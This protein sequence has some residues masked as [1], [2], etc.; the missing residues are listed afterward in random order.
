MR[1]EM[2]RWPVPSTLSAD[3]IH[4]SDN[5]AERFEFRYD[6]DQDWQ[7]RAAWLDSTS[8]LKADRLALADVLQVYNRKVGNTAPEVADH[9]DR[10]RGGAFAVVG[11]QQAGLFGGPL[12][13]IYKAATIIRTAKEASAKLRRDVVPVFWIAGEDHDFDEVN[14]TYVT[15]GEADGTPKKIS[16]SR[17]A[18]FMQAA[19]SDTPITPEQWHDCLDELSLLLPDTEFKPRL[20]DKAAQLAAHA[21]TLSDSFASLLGWLFGSYGLVVMDAADAGIRRLEQPM[22]AAMLESSHAVQ[23]AAVKGKLAVQSLGYEPQVVFDDAMAHLFT[24]DAQGRRPLLAHDGVFQ[25]KGESAS[26]KLD[27]MLDRLGNNPSA[28]S[29]NV[30][31]RPVMQE[32]L[33]PVV[34]TVLG[35]GEISY[36]GMLKEMFAVFGMRMPIAVPRTEVTVIDT[37]TSKLM[38]K[39]GLS[40][41]RAMLQLEEAKQAWLT[42]QKP[43]Q[44]TDRFADTKKH[45][46]R[47]YDPLFDSLSGIHTG[48]RQLGQAN[49][50]KLLEQVDYLERRTDAEIAARHAQS[51]EQWDYMAAQIHPFGKRQ[52]RV[53]NVWGYLNSFGSTFIKEVVEQPMQPGAHYVLYI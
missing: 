27:D 2:F 53:L 13:V 17:E 34:A 4:V 38:N 51:L 49:L 8:H 14:H 16:I 20:M 52:E 42:A 9:I 15:A 50:R 33:F 46:A 31:T 1:M 22:F 40:I 26:Y 11:G 25:V 41:D 12:L 29:N 24:V 7:S 3:Y 21:D 35:S 18:A 44:L 30:M 47:L 43:P 6:R 39:Y 5:T 37:A 10:L 19:V 48:M 23:Q 28:F 45:I 36:W 32:Y